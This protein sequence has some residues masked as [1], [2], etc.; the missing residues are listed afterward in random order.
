MLFAADKAEAAKKDAG[1]AVL[2]VRGPALRQV[3]L[4]NDIKFQGI[5]WCL[6]LG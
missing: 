6:R 4:A 5:G 2:Q 1:Y 3:F